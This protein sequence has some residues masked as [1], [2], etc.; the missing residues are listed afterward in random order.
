MLS[1]DN[2]VAN[3]KALPLNVDFIDGTEITVSFLPLSHIAAQMFDIMV[4]LN[5]GGCVYFADRDALRGSLIKT[6]VAAR[7]TRFFA[8]P[9]VLEKMRERLKQ[10]EAESSWLKQQIL[11][12][13]RYAMMECHLN[14]DGRG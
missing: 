1:H 3:A 9:R 6:L 10:V 14:H 4:S 5:D 7:P 8:V 12:C 13:A 2:I 11:R